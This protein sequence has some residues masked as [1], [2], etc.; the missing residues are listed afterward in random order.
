M[1]LILICLV[2]FFM[3][4]KLGS[5]TDKNLQLGKKQIKVVQ[6]VLNTFGYDAGEIDGVNGEKTEHLK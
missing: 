1:P 2:A 4:A 3:F 6:R 5:A